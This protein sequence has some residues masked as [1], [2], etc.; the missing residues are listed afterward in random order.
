MYRR[1]LRCG[2]FTTDQAARTGRCPACAGPLAANARPALVSRPAVSARAGLSMAH[3]TGMRIRSYAEE[4]VSPV[5]SILASVAV[6]L[7]TIGQ[8][9]WMMHIGRTNTLIDI[10]DNSFLGMGLFGAWIFAMVVLAWALMRF[11]RHHQFIHLYWTTMVL[12][13]VL[14]IPPFLM[15]GPWMSPLVLVLAWLIAPAIQEARRR[16]A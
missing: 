16:L 3:P 10:S 8:L 7:I 11:D 6:V 4:G 14:F 15:I 1:C 9:A 5:A 2:A 12:L 13:I